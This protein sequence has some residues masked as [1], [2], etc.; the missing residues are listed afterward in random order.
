MDRQS[1][2]LASLL[3]ELSISVSDSSLMRMQRFKE[4]LYDHNKRFNLTSIGEAD[5][6]TLHIVDSLITLVPG[7]MRTRAS[8]IDIGCGAGFPGIPIKIVRSD[9]RLT[10]LDATQK[11]IDFIKTV[12]HDLQLGH[13]QAIHGRAELL[14][15]DPQH[16]EQYDVVLSRA[17]ADLP[18]L[19]EY[20]M[21]LVKPGGICIALKGKEDAADD[22]LLRLIEEFSGTLLKPY[23]CT[24]PGMQHEERTLLRIHK[25]EAIKDRYPRT[26]KQIRKG[27]PI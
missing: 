10:L 14:G 15:N 7:D 6:D 4:L 3:E 21:P 12:I 8:V 20:M 11:K 27:T 16:R 1:S 13:C 25:K 9:I 22:T 2:H 24:L 18:V 23:H 17:L 5:Y 26:E 19:L